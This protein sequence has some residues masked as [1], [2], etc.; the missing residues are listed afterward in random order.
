MNGF[1]KIRFMLSVV[2]QLISALWL[3]L[4]GYYVAMFFLDNKNPLKH[5]YLIGM[6]LG[7]LY[8]TGFT[9]GSAILASSLKKHL[10]KTVF[11]ALTMPALIIGSGFFV[12][13]LY[14]IVCDLA[15]RT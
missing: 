14:S 9:L 13:N 15:T 4:A 11:R 2:V 8:A 6:W 3:L 1:Q 7:I 12:L 5:E 10:S